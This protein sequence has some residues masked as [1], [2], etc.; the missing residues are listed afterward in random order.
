MIPGSNVGARQQTG[1]VQT[2]DVALERV[3]PTDND[4]RALSIRLYGS[5]RYAGVLVDYNRQNGFLPNGALTPG[6]NI[7]KPPSSILERGLSAQANPVRPTSIPGSAVRVGEPL[8]LTA[9]VT[10]PNPAVVGVQNPTAD[11]TR[12]YKVQNSKGESILDI[13][14]RVLGNRGRWNEIYRLNPTYRPEFPIPYGA[15]LRM[16]AS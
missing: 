11:A 1:V 12:S 3:Q 5:D 4:A 14:E 13:A 15:E 6:Q 7:L 9:S 8:P 2:T 16:P 10:A